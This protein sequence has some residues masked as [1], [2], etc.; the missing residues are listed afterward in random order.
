MSLFN[1][2][3]LRPLDDELVQLFFVEAADQV[4]LLDLEAL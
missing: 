1:A 2:G 3:R 4:P